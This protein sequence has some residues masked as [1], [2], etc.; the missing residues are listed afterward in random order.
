MPP[1]NTVTKIAI[2]TTSYILIP[3]CGLT[4]KLK[5]VNMRR[6]LPHLKDPINK[7]IEWAVFELNGEP[8]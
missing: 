2:K 5:Y 3:R 6:A 4:P 8:A 1:A 7:R